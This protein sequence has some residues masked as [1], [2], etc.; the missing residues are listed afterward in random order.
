MLFLSLEYYC[1]QQ[2]YWLMIS[3]TYAKTE[4]DFLMLLIILKI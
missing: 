3:K 1:Y 2:Y 4:K